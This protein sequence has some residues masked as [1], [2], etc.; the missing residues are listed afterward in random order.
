MNILVNFLNKVKQKCVEIEAREYIFGRK[1]LA[2]IWLVLPPV[3][4]GSKWYLVPEEVMQEFEKELKMF[5]ITIK[6]AYAKFISFKEWWEVIKGLTID[7]KIELSHRIIDEAIR[8]TKHHF[9]KVNAHIAFS[10]GKASLVTAWLVLQHSDQFDSLYLY[11][12]NT[13]NEHLENV[14]YVRK[15]FKWVKERFR[16]IK[17]IEMIPNSQFIT[18]WK[19]WKTFGFP[20]EGRSSGYEPI[21]CV[22]LKELPC[23]YVIEKFNINLEFLG[24][25]FTES[26]TR[27]TTLDFLGAIRRHYRLGRNIEIPTVTRCFPIAWFTDLELWQLIEKWK[28]PKNP[29]YEKYGISR[30]GCVACTN[31]LDWRKNLPK[32][33]PSLY[34]FVVEKMKE[35][36][37]QTKSCSLNQILEKMNLKNIPLDRL[38]IIKEW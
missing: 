36:G 5:E 17:C 18:P 24:V 13:L 9:N 14:E 38:Y 4:E 6:L 33:N 32:I 20:K 3:Y 16:N 25:Q 1:K 28:L 37:I 19:I 29:V 11:Y 26:R 15:F 34:N 21:C 10:G 12:E 22:L 23:K 7:E 35:W 27:Q 8:I 31:N 2:Q 30:Q